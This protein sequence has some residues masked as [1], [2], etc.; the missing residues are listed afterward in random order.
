[1]MGGG[2]VDKRRIGTL[3]ERIAEAFLLL[4]GYKVLRR[5]YRVAGREI[6]LLTRKDDRLVAV[7][8]KLRRGNRFGAA[9]QAIDSRKIGRIRF[10]L[11]AALSESELRPQVDAVVID[12]TD[13]STEMVLRHLE[14][15]A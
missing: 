15:V 1:M 11:A 13:D 5:N 2:E 8:V 7:E 6:D 4:K 3:G 9:V 12:L 10:A 14:A